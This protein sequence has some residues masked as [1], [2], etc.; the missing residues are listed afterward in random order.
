MKSMDR[1]L[2]L[3]TSESRPVH[4]VAVIAYASTATK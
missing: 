3:H 2:E 4:L 1:V